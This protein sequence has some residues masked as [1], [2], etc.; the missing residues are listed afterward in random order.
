ME[1]GDYIQEL[2]CFT[3]KW[4]EIKNEIFSDQDRLPGAAQWA[5]EV[6]QEGVGSKNI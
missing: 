1:S 6:L 3:L 2:I 5:S 4:V